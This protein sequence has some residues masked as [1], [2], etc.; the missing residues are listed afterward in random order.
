[1]NTYTD[2]DCLLRG[3]RDAVAA[4]RYQRVDVIALADL[5]CYATQMMA[6]GDAERLARWRVGDLMARG[7]AALDGGAAR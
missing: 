2:T 6:G 3:V 1:M 4:E 5:A 7:R